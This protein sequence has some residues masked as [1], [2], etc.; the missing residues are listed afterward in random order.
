MTNELT[1]L[2]AYPNRFITADH[3]KG[4]RLALTIER[5]FQEG[6]DAGKGAQT[7][8]VVS[9]V[10]SKLQLVLN[11]TNAFCLKTMFGISCADWEQ[12]RVVWFPSKTN[13]KG[14]M[15]DCIRVYGS[16]DIEADIEISVPQGFKP[17]WETTLHAVKPGARTATATA[18]VPDPDPTIIEAWSNLGWSR[19]EGHKEMGGF[20]GTDYLSHLSAL[21]DQANSVEVF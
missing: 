9:F 15:V 14:K 21:I 20:T 6:L 10:G 4:K 7:K 19:E 2:T 1:Y 13:F 3:F 8:V 17:P 11:K 5:V 12:K 16:L 18:T